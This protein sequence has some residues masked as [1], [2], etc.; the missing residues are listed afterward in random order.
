MLSFPVQPHLMPQNEGASISPEHA[1]AIPDGVIVEGHGPAIVLLHSSMASKS[2]WRSLMQRMCSTHRLIAID[3]HGYGDNAMPE[4]HGRFALSE[5]VRLVESKLKHLLGP[6]ERFHLVGHSFGGGVALRLAHAAPERL[7]SL[8][9]YEP[10]AFH[11]LEASDPIFQE[12]VAIAHATQAAIDNGRT[13]EGAALFID[14]WNGVGSYAT[15]P[16]SRQALLTSLLLK[17]PLDF[18]AL[19]ED[20]LRCSDYRQIAVPT[21]LLAGRRSP[22]CARA[23]V[24]VLAAV[25]H[26]QEMHQV[27]AG[28]MAPLTHP[29]IINPI[30]D[31]FI[32]GVEAQSGTAP[33][34]IGRQL[35]PLHDG[36]HRAVS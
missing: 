20:P 21:C 19:L 11:L 34:Q 24:S 29:N 7:A 9:L 3:L 8:S 30:I 16:P 28:H 13:A 1:T 18:Q 2:Q 10:T 4:C 6:A 14:Y 23:I 31:G 15:L 27:D 32:R 26:R 12:V 35:C 22:V 5:E 33:T 17:V 25:L 36:Q